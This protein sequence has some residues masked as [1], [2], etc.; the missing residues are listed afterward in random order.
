M[1]YVLYTINKMIDLN[2]LDAPIALVSGSK[3]FL[4]ATNIQQEIN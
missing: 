1:V 4:R 3:I 2:A